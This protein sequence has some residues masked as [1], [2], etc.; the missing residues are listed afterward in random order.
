MSDR[1]TRNLVKF[2]AA[3]L[4]LMA[5]MMAN[6]KISDWFTNIGTEAVLIIGVVTIIVACVGVG[7]AAMGLI[8]LITAKRN[9]QPTEH[10]PWY[11]GG[12]VLCILLVPLLIGIGDSITDGNTQDSVDGFMSEQNA[13]E[14]A[15]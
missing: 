10:Q 15:Q 4:L 9:K 13:F 1:L 7:L 5:P 3:V 12:G 11:I 8:S 2:Y 14:Q 6:A